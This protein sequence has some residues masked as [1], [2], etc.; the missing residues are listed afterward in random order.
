MLKKIIYYSS[1]ILGLLLVNIGHAKEN[2]NEL[3]QLL[4]SIYSMTANFQQ[5][6]Y[7]NQQKV[8]QKSFGYMAIKKPGLFRWQ[9]I[10]PEP[11]LIIVDG[12]NLWNYDEELQ[13][14]TVQ[15]IDDSYESSPVSLLLAGDITDIIK[16]YQITKVANEQFELVPKNKVDS[17]NKINLTFKSGVLSKLQLFAQLGQMS[18]IQF[19]K[20][21]TNLIIKAKLFQFVPP[22][23]VDVVG[24]QQ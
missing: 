13:Q 23:G 5:I 12:K 1:L 9:I 21:K 16:K 20:V 4:Q 8:V 17:F 14:V 22:V 18:V 2:I 7:N 6:V 11:N 15:A 10:N 3:G 19:D 24:E